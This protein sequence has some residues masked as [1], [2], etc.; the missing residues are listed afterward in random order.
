MSMSIFL[1]SQF[2]KIIAEKN[3]CAK[4]SSIACE[5]T[6]AIDQINFYIFGHIWINFRVDFTGPE[7]TSSYACGNSFFDLAGR[8][9]PRQDRTTSLTT[10]ADLE[11]QR[12]PIQC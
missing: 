8:R 11:I 5:K 6:D 9:L 4:V 10:F 2:K 3:F 12:S 1:L 7:G